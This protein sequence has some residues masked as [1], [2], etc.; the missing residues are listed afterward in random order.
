MKRSTKL[1]Q[2]RSWLFLASNVHVYGPSLGAQ[3]QSGEVSEDSRHI[4][5]ALFESVPEA[6]VISDE[7]GC[8]VRVNVQVERLFGYSRDELRGQPIEI[9][10]PEQFRHVRLGLGD[11]QDHRRGALDMGLERCGKHKDGKEGPVDLLLDFKVEKRR[12]TGQGIVRW[13]AS[14]EAEIGVEITY[15]DDHNRAWILSLTA[16]NKSV[17]FIPRTTAV[18][19]APALGVGG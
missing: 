13:I 10:L 11:S 14:S 2:V 4:L 18:A 5:E 7:Q 1:R 6:V 12:V 3:K 16:P 9:L 17:S 8:I 19:I 15:I